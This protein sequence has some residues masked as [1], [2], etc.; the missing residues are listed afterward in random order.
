MTTALLSYTTSG[1][2]TGVSTG[3]PLSLPMAQVKLLRDWGNGAPLAGWPLGDSRLRLVRDGVVVEGEREQGEILFASRR[4]RRL[5]T[6]TGSVP[7]ISGC[8]ARTACST[9]STAVLWSVSRAAAFAVALAD[10]HPE[11]VPTFVPRPV[12]CFVASAPAG[13]IALFATQNT[14]SS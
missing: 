13:A 1:D 5:S 9:S 2:T 4:R 14:G 3:V 7:A 11:L 6:A 12:L 10:I 8:M